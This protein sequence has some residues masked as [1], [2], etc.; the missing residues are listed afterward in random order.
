MRKLGRKVTVIL[1][2]MTMLLSTT[3][4]IAILGNHKVSA[5]Q[6]DFAGGTGTQ[7]DPY[8]ISNADQLNAVRNYLGAGIYFELTNDIDLSSYVTSNGGQGWSPIGNISGYFKGNFYGDGYTI[9]NLYINRPTT[10]LQG[11]FGIID[12]SA[13]ISDINLIDV[14]IKGMNSTASLV[15]QNNGTVNA[16]T[17]TGKA[18]GSSFVG[19]LVGRNYGGKVL[20]SSAN[21]N[22]SSTGYYIGGLIGYGDSG[23]INNNYATGNVSGI[24]YIGGLIGLATTNNAF[25][26]N[27]ATGNVDGSNEVGGLIGNSNNI[28]TNSFALGNVTGSNS[29]GGL[30]GNNLQVLINS[31]ATGK[32]TG[33]SGTGGL[34]G[35]SSNGITI[36]NGFYNEETTGQSDSGKGESVSTAEMQVAATYTNWTFDAN[37]WT[38]DPLHNN[39]YPYLSQLPVPEHVIYSGNGNT[40][41]TVPTT[42]IYTQDQ[43]IIVDDNSGEL[44]KLGYTFFGWNTEPDGRGD[45]YEPGDLYIVGADVTFYA[46]W[47]QDPPVLTADTTDNDVINDIEIT[48][49][50]D[51]TWREE[52]T[53]IV[54]DGDTLSEED[55]SIEAGKITLFSNVL[56]AATYKI[57]VVAE[58][59]TDATVQQIILSNLNLSNLLLSSGALNETFTSSKS[60]YTQE[61]VYGK[62][63]LTVTPT[64]ENSATIVK[65]SV[66]DEDSEIVTSGEESADLPLK[67]GANTIT[68]IVTDENEFSKEYTVVVTRGEANLNLSNLALSSGTLNEAFTSS[69]TSYTQEVA[70]GKTSLTVTPTALEPTAIVEVSVNDEDSEIV[71]TGE[72]S[73]V[74]P[75]IVGEN[76]I[77]VTVTVGNKPSKMYTVVVTRGEASLD[78]SNL[79]LSSGALNKTFTGLETNYTQ[80]VSN[81]VSSLTVTPT[82]VEPTAVVKVSVNGEASTIV[83]SGAASATLP[84]KVGA[85]TITITVTV[86]NELSKVY[87]VVV[88]RKAAS[89]GN[90]GSTPIIDP[91]VTSSNGKITIPTGSTGTVTLDNEVTVA[92]PVNATNNDVTITIEKLLETNNLLANDELLASHVFEILKNFPENFSKP[93]TLTFMFDPNKVGS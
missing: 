43:E 60:S 42:K 48:F 53:D 91:N 8:Q 56:S 36:S 22:I 72:A 5:A 28:V 16:V 82:V 40:G 75:L 55:Y 74:L 37:V 61:V 47:L 71:K 86:G 23:V 70:Y 14:N 34:I 3:Q 38:I 65:V 64:V 44:S 45:T 25:D 46:A 58:G 84:L 17:A 20:S 41:G 29:V 81:G 79:V 27:Y 6:L 4:Q 92:I 69:K 18:S 50:D 63:S 32:V 90:G 39:G 88:T 11:L 21:V 54:A 9:S 76:T 31:Y 7:S 33:N 51:P 62:T 78:L 59:Y 12:Y 57:V 1:L 93:A 68:V 19:G 2:A 49:A 77:T 24:M 15:G 26:K 73:N 30:I 80:D 87:T 83:A 52:I 10:D 89:S 67:V 85:N 66:N 13:L 35:I